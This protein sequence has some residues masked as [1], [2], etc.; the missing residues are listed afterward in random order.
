M[1]RKRKIPTKP[2][3]KRATKRAYDFLVELDIKELPVNPHKIVEMFEDRWHLLSWSELKNATGVDDPFHLKRDNAEAKT[4]IERGTG[5]YLIVYDDSFSRERIRWTIAH[6]IGHILLGHLV[7]YEETA[8]N[9]GGLTKDQY[10]VL[11]VEA[12]WFAEALLAPNFLLHMYDIKDSQDIAFLCDISKESADKC[13]G[14]LQNYYPNDPTVE[15]ILLRNF[16]EFFYK[17]RHLQSIAEGIFK[18]HNSYLYDDFYKICRICRNCNSFVVNENQNYCHICGDKLP[19]F[20]WPFKELPVNGMWRGWPEYLEGK[21]YPYIET[22]DT[23]KVLFCPVCK[24]HVYSEDAVYCKIC[25]TP[26]RNTCLHENKEVSGECRHCPDCGEITRFEELG[27]FGNL[28]EVELPDLLTF[29]NGA[30]EDYIEYE[31]WN[32]IIATV[33]YFEKD[34]ELYTALAGSRAIRDEGSFVIFAA[35]AM[36]ADVIIK[37]RDLIAKCIRKYGKTIITGVGCWYDL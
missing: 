29:D 9:R 11:E 33:Y 1:P 5:E 20:D 19:D 24:N 4:Q 3:F 17:D 31:Y 22:D 30:Y 36:S 35:D 2:N 37:S 10:G 28:K 34:L 12:H 21:F 16:Y 13:E 27:L 8:L 15:G 14:H 23:N 7:Y 6:E 25:G 26:L 32:Y 18:F